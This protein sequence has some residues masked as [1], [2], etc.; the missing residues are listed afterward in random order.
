MILAPKLSKFIALSI[1]AFIHDNCLLHFIYLSIMCL[2]L[3]NSMPE[4]LFEDFQDQDF[5]ESE[6]SFSG[7]QGKCP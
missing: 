4:L 5:E 3:G 2:A 6:V 1:L 7:Q